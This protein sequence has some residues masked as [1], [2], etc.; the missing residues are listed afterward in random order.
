MQGV[1]I[2]KNCIEKKTSSF[3]VEK[4]K[5]LMCKG[6]KPYEHMDKRGEV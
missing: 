6:V 4:I 5:L 2:V 1:M 3:I